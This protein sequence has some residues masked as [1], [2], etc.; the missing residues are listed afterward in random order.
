MV[1]LKAHSVTIGGRAYNPDKSGYPIRPTAFGGVEVSFGA[2]SCIEHPEA[3]KANLSLWV[4][5]TNV[6]YLPKLDEEVVV[7]A[8]FEGDPR[9][10]TI[11][12]GN[13]E[14]V[15]LEDDHKPA[16]VYDPSVYYGTKVFD[17]NN[18]TVAAWTVYGESPSV[19]TATALTDGILTILMDEYTEYDEQEEAY[20]Y[21]RNTEKQPVQQNK[22]YSVEATATGIRGEIH[23][24]FYDTSGTFI[25]GRTVSANS[26]STITTPANATQMAF[27]YA[28]LWVPE[29]SPQVFIGP[30]VVRDPATA[31]PAPASVP[32]YRVNI[33]CSDAVAAAG[34]LRIGTEPW[35]STILT[36][37]LSD[38]AQLAQP[39][40][41]KFLDPYLGDNLYGVPTNRGGDEMLGIT[42]RAR[43]VDSVSALEVYQNTTMSGGNTVGSI[44]NR[45][46][47]N[48]KL[49]MP[50]VLDKDAT[51]VAIIE[52]VTS[53]YTDQPIPVIPVG[54]IVDDTF[55]LDTTETISQVKL[56]YFVRKGTGWTSEHLA[57]AEANMTLDTKAN[58]FAAPVTRGLKTESQV[59]DP[60]SSLQAPK[61]DSANSVIIKARGLLAGQ[62]VPRW[63]L[64]NGLSIVLKELPYMTGLQ[65]LI[66]E[67]GRFGQLV[68][69]DGVPEHIESYQRIRAGRIVLGEQASLD[70]ELEPVD[71]SAPTALTRNTAFA[72]GSTAVIKIG[73]LQNS[74][75][76]S[77]DLRSIGAR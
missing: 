33:Q 17:L 44:N 10:S 6:E 59:E 66:D 70:F 62:S 52:E 53:K 24:W 11:F 27:G 20:L 30:F 73:D 36:K 45:V 19:H 34:R 50:R 8:R 25:D 13:V 39:S 15:M 14:S 21:V 9:P 76:T 49:L 68:R 32:G 63:R 22:Q 51:G 72:D 40:G 41:V 5:K 61:M 16:E 43:D 23:I 4:P 1:A 64:S 67:T 28:D 38:I 54:A 46:T 56:E 69:I 12:S 71:Y 57:I 31:T 55:T 37:R 48:F 75:I 58:K 74:G 2:P 3:T 77:N 7:T 35:A 65:D 42:V 47:P 18:T 29:G 26:I 60:Y